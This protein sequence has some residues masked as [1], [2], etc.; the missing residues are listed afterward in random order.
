MAERSSPQIDTKA[1]AKIDAPQSAAPA[2]A[3]DYAPLAPEIAPATQGSGVQVALPRRSPENLLALQRA[4]GN[5]VVVRLLEPAIARSPA[6]SPLVQREPPTPSNIAGDPEA[7]AKAAYDAAPISPLANVNDLISLIERVEAAYPSEGWQGITTRLRKSYYDDALWNML[8]KDRATYDKVSSPPLSMSDFK[9]LATA[10]NHPEILA[11]NG[12]SI[13]IGHVFT[14]I[15][16]SNFPNTGWK[17]DVAGI[18]GPAAAT[19]SGDVGSAL[20][21]W[22]M[23]DGSERA[24]RKSYYDRFASKDDML[25]DVDAIALA[26]EPPAPGAGGDKLSARLR[27]FYIPPA[28]GGVNKRFTKFAQASG[29]KYVGKG[30][31]IKL[32][33]AARSKIRAQVDTFAVQYRRQKKGII[34]GAGQNWFHNEDIDFFVNLFTSWVEAGLAVENP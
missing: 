4:V 7:A 16:S 21:E 23:N 34:G 26:A 32:D 3:V 14:G 27:A 9:A 17:M 28:G 22:D 25:G 19:W 6:P 15:D 8:I 11:P 33:G 12:D 31:G 10:K 30:G 1:R 29:F 2:S 5:T 18:D 13:D 20:A 24:K